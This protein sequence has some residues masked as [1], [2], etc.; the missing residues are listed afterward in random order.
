MN[1][2]QGGDE[3]TYEPMLSPTTPDSRL[4]LLASLCLSIIFLTGLGIVS[5]QTQEAHTHSRAMPLRGLHSV[6]GASSR[7]EEQ[8][9]PCVNRAGPPA[10]VLGG[11]V[12]GSEAAG[13]EGSK[14]S[15]A[16]HSS[17][18]Q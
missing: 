4:Q 16:G 6:G 15:E 14:I 17:H 13:Q 18:S 5:A 8:P 12:P 9:L 2:T 10:I 1:V 3:P 11:S 7:Q